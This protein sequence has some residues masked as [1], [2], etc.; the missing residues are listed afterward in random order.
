MAEALLRLLGKND[1]EVVSAGLKPAFEV[2]PIAIAALRERGIDTEGLHSKKIN[3]ELREMDFDLIVTTCDHARDNAPSFP[4][5]KEKMHWSI[6]DPAK[7]RGTY[8]EILE[9]F[10]RVR[11]EI[12]D[13]IKAKIL[14]R[15]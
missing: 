3:D 7:V 10:R 13:R 1:Y 8:Y 11:K 6:K 2:H 4:N 14:N 9:V 12:E 5:A 15:E